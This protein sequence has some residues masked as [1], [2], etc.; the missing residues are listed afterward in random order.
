MESEGIAIGLGVVFMIVG[1]IFG[2]MDDK[3]DK[4][5]KKIWENSQ[6]N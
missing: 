6:N 3:R 1:L 4:V 5:A 2:W